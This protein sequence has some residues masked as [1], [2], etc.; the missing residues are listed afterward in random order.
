LVLPQVQQVLL[1]LLVLWNQLDLLLVLEYLAVQYFLEYLQFLVVPL[2]Q[3]SHYFLEIL[4]LPFFLVVQLVLVYLVALVVQL[5]LVVLLYLV[6]QIYLLHLE[7]LEHLEYLVVLL[8]RLN[9]AYIL[10]NIFII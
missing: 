7:Y 5:Y 10:Y 6:A 2:V 4:S 8:V 9:Q 1:H 3:L